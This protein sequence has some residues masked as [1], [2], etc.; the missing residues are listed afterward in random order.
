M[1]TNG[2]SPTMKL[3]Y[4]IVLGE[5]QFIDPQGDTLTVVNEYTL[6]RVQIGQALYYNNY[7]QGYY[8]VIAS[9][10]VLKLASQQVMQ[11]IRSEDVL[12]NG[13]G[14]S[15]GQSTAARSVRYFDTS[16]K[17][18]K[19]IVLTRKVF[20]FIIDQ[21]ERIYPASRANLMKIGK[22]HNKALAR[23]LKDESINFKKE[24]DLKKVLTFFSQL[25]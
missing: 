21:N 18:L 8:E 15:P 4:N 14:T 9:Y 3:N 25:G 24:E 17:I 19:D 12:N 2:T 11:Q 1:Y 5:M 10:P 23:Y 20:Y 7:K 6:E 22:K 13:Y 16:Q